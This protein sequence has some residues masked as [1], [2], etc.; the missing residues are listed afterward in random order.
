M[1]RS[2]SRAIQSD[3]AR[4]R[5]ARAFTAPA[6]CTAP[7]YSRNFSVRV[8][9]PASGWL[10]MANVRRRAASITGRVSRGVLVAEVMSREDPRREPVGQ[11]TGGR[12]PSLGGATGR[13]TPDE[14]DVAGAAPC[15]TLAFR[16]AKVSPQHVPEH[17]SDEGVESNAR[18]TAATAAVLLVLLA[19]EGV[20]ILRIHALL[21]PHV[22]IGMLL[23]PP[24]LLKIGSTGWR[25]VR[26]YRGA[27]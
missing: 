20:T 12:P 14:S 15:P 25:F 26:Y 4:R 23:V 13:L 9:L 27:A 10:M 1:P 11:C 18:L 6:S 19:A 22:V 17:S 7:A 21:T 3:V 8:V 2:C 24:I 16:M 5:P